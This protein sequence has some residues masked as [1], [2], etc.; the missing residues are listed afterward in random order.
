VRLLPARRTTVCVPCMQTA[1]RR[2]Y[3]GSRHHRR[4]RISG[5]TRIRVPCSIPG[6]LDFRHRRRFFHS[7]TRWSSPSPTMMNL[8]TP[9]YAG[10][11]TY[12][13]M[14][15]SSRRW[16]VSP[17]NFRFKNRKP[18]HPKNPDPTTHALHAHLTADQPQLISL[19]ETTDLRLLIFL[20]LNNLGQI[21]VSMED[22]G[23]RHKR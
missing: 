8:G 17:D 13:E 4:K 22:I 10:T 14:N 19:A 1:F 9:S 2:E 15:W 18:R 21:P 3:S 6:R 11:S 5:H 23:C 16:P 20:K 12:T 7:K